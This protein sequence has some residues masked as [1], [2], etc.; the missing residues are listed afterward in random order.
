MKLKMMPMTK[1]TT[2]KSLA[3]TK[4]PNL[5]GNGN[6]GHGRKIK[7]WAATRKRIFLR[8]KY[9]CQVCR[10]V[11]IDLECDHIVNLA[12]GGSEGDSNLQAICVPCH[13]LKT[14]KESRGGI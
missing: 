13:K 12:A 7:G 11:T 3:E 2:T 14:A 1:L 5:K 8:D 6:W 10:V 4:H 9:T